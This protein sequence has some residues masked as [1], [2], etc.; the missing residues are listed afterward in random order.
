MGLLSILDHTAVL[1]LSF[2]MLTNLLYRICSY[3]WLYV[4]YETFILNTRSLLTKPNYEIYSNHEFMNRHFS[5]IVHCYVNSIGI[6]L[7]W[8]VTMQIS[9]FPKFPIDQIKNSYSVP[10]HILNFPH[11][12]NENAKWDRCIHCYSRLIGYI[13]WL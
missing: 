12:S 8:H 13:L 11:F 5:T 4:H 9:E 7:I 6:L 2:R 1:S 10:F 3:Y